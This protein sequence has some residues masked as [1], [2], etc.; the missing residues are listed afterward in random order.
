[1]E[2]QYEEDQKVGAG[3]KTICILHFVFGGIALALGLLSFAILTPE[4]EAQTG[5]TSTILL[6]SVV[7]TIILIIASIL[8]LLKK[9]AVLR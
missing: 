7:S 6:L 3:I 5:V 1:M 2:Y 8:I 9:K 4:I